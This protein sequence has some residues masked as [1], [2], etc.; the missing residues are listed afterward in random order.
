MCIFNKKKKKQNK[1]IDLIFR[2]ISGC[3]VLIFKVKTIIIILL[4]L[5]MAFKNHEIMGVDIKVDNNHYCKE[6]Y[7]FSYPFHA[8]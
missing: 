6:E 3:G 7:L 2:I 5:G 4:T 1:S 8:L